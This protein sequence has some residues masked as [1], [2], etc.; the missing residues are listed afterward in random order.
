MVRKV[1]ITT[2]TVLAVATLIPALLSYYAPLERRLDRGR[3]TKWFG[4]AHGQIY[5]ERFGDAPNTTVVGVLQTTMLPAYEFRF[6]GFQAWD[7][8]AGHGGIHPE[9]TDPRLAG[10]KRLAPGQWETGGFVITLMI[11]QYRISFFA[12]PFWMPLVLFAAY[13]LVAFVRGPLRRARRAKR[14]ACPECGYD[15]TGNVSGRCPECAEPV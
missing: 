3:E 15:L 13:P 8:I 10:W 14:G 4:V 7:C 5:F 1:I 12:L 6:L 11:S 2:L 9:G